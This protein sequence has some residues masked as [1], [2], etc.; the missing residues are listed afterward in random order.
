MHLNLRKDKPYCYRYCF[1]YQRAFIMIWSTQEILNAR[2][3]V[4]V[5]CRFLVADRSLR[6][7]YVVADVWTNLFCKI[8]MALV[9][10]FCKGK[11][12][13]LRCNANR[14]GIGTDWEYGSRSHQWIWSQEFTAWNKLETSTHRKS[15]V[16]LQLKEVFNSRCC[17]SWYIFDPILI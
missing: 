5:N 17:N 2:K 3:K 14:H 11:F 4:G 10:I 1:L 9:W 7:L 8:F 13:L 6:V 15:L 16:Y 12:D